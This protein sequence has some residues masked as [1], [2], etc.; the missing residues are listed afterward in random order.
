[1]YTLESGQ[2]QLDGRMASPG[3]EPTSSAIKLTKKA[4]RKAKRAKGGYTMPK[5]GDNRSQ[6]VSVPVGKQNTCIP[7]NL[8]PMC[9]AL[10]PELCLPLDSSSQRWNYA[11]RWWRPLLGSSYE[12]RI[13]PWHN[14]RVSIEHQQPALAMESVFR[15]L[16][17]SAAHQDRSGSG[18]LPLCWIPGCSQP[19]YG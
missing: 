18:R 19:D 13:K 2:Q 15:L 10:D 14:L 17:G 11:N 1:M 3:A 6:G 16:S 4:I 12:L 7:Y 5:R 8:W 9:N